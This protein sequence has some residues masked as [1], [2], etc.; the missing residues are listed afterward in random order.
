MISMIKRLLSPEEF[1]KELGLGVHSTRKLAKEG[2]I[3]CIH[4]G[5]NIKIPVSEIEDFPTRVAQGNKTK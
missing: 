3:K 2:V 1:S 5:R 4:V